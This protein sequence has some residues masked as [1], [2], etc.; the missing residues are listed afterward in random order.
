MSLRLYAVSKHHDSNAWEP[1]TILVGVYSN[2]EKAIAACLEQSMIDYP[3]V[4]DIGT[5]N[6]EGGQLSNLI[7]DHSKIFGCMWTPQG[8]K[9]GPMEYGELI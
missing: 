9:F 3:A 5:I 4:H 1:V 6:P 8:P 7:Y 2:K